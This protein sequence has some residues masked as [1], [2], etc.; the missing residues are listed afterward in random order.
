MNHAVPVV[1]FFVWWWLLRSCN[2]WT[3]PSHKFQRHWQPTSQR[4]QLP[5]PNTAL[6]SSF[7]WPETVAHAMRLSQ[8]SDCNIT[9][10]HEAVDLWE[11]VL[12]NEEVLPNMNSAVQSL[13]R[14]LYG[15]CLVRI[16]RDSTAI[17]VFAQVLYQNDD[18]PSI[19]TNTR[20]NAIL[21]R[22]ACF[23]RLLRYH[24]ALE[25]YQTIGAPAGTWGAVVCAL[26]LGDAVR[27]RDILAKDKS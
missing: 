20:Q 10:A 15:A 9:A 24:E 11:S 18:L 27:A 5:V 25:E 6:F 7:P 14:T 17:G 1:F 26:R 16:G 21:G 12:A 8:N 3:L 23:Q 4:L 2:A 19:D 22:A 13:C